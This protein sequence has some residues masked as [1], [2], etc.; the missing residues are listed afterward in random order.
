MKYMLMMHAPRTGWKD[1]GIGTWPPAD[2]KAHMSR[3]GGVP[4]R[5]AFAFQPLR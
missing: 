1:A 3:P 5:Q 4:Q 2:I